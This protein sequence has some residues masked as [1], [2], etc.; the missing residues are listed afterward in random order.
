MNLNMTDAELREFCIEYPN[1][2]L[3]VKMRDRIRELEDERLSQ[4]KA[5]AA[6]REA[7]GVFIKGVFIKTGESA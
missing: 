7:K 5:F 2:T 3:L 4:D 1:Y 6:Y